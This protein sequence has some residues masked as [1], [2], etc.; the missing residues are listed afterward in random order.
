MGYREPMKSM[1]F[2]WIIW[3]IGAALF[4]I[5]GLLTKLQTTLPIPVL[6]F[7]GRQGLIAW[8]IWAIAFA[9]M[10]YALVRLD[11]ASRRAAII[12]QIVGGIIMATTPI[13]PSND[14][15]AYF[16]YGDMAAHHQDAWQPPHLSATQDQVVAVGIIP[17]HNPPPPCVYG[18]VFVAFE[19]ALVTILSPH[20]VLALL[21]T[22]RAL[23]LAAVI[24]V[25]LVIRSRSI[26][27]W[28]LHPLVLFEAAV[29]AHNDVLVLLLIAV[30][31]KIRR[32]WIAGPVLACSG[33]IKIVAF[34]AA[35]YRPKI[36][37]S[38]AAFAAVF[39]FFNHNA[40]ALGQLLQHQNLTPLHSPVMLLRAVLRHGLRL[41]TN[42]AVIAKCVLAFAAI[43][44]SALLFLGPARRRMRRDRPV[45][46][47][48]IF[49]GGMLSLVY[50]WYFTWIVFAAIFAHRR[51]RLSSAILGSTSFVLYLQAFVSTSGKIEY[52]ATILFWSAVVAFVLFN[53]KPLRQNSSSSVRLQSYRGETQEIPCEKN[54][55]VVKKV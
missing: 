8:L 13:M 12:A 50:P 24:A 37:F 26:S 2:A 33:M 1:R 47:T 39:I 28:A 7:S 52:P 21:L 35:A 42:A 5:G 30:S 22:Q 46:A 36:F 34:G 29:G 45:Y 51:A 20:N 19:A 14:P 44:G 32:S 54:L 40:L 43:C 27:S 55:D 18:P 6:F 15:F 31:M 4:P 41:G 49:I 3:I 38:A 17:W 11:G 48:L 16:M 10:T 9:F 53:V 23:S 25:S